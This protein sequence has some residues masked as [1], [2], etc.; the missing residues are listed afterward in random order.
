MSLLKPVRKVKQKA[1]SKT[2]P[3]VYTRRGRGRRTKRDPLTL[4]PK[5]RS[6]FER[7]FWTKNKA[8]IPMEFEPFHIIG[9]RIQKVRYL[10][11]F[12]IKDT[13]HSPVVFETKGWWRPPDR[14]KL[15]CI[16]E[17]NPAVTVIMVFQAD[18]KIRKGSKTKYSDYCTRNRIPFVI[19]TDLSKIVWP[20][21]YPIP[22][23]KGVNSR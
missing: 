4:E 5:F 16:L 12:V 22:K 15:K 19:G 13:P 23:L 14:T 7:E 3:A 11:D 9:E 17:S 21:N 1:E 18:N 20:E 6:E 8:K 10:P 2:R